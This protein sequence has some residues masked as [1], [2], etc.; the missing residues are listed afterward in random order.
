[1]FEQLLKQ[2][3]VV[4]SKEYKELLEE[5]NKLMANII[6]TCEVCRDQMERAKFCE[7]PVRTETE[8]RLFNL[9]QGMLHNA[10]DDTKSS[11]WKN[12]CFNVGLKMGHW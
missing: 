1:M 12:R 11:Y 8:M 4:E 3:M 7:G 5:R 9:I 10:R 6:A 2:K